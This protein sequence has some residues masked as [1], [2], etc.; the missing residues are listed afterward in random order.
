MDVTGG[1]GGAC[2]PGAQ[3]VDHPQP[4]EEAGGVGAG[5]QPTQ[6]LAF[7]LVSTTTALHTHTQHA[8]HV[9]APPSHPS[10][11]GSF[12]WPVACAVQR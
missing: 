5:A 3:A 6:A 12:S 9:H 4:G 7:L 1:G 2:D 11:I 10:R 8:C